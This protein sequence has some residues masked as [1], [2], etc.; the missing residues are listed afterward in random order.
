MEDTELRDVMIKGEDGEDWLE[1]GEFIRRGGEEKMREV[2][3]LEDSDRLG[4]VLGDE[5]IPDMED[6][7]EEDD[8][9]IIRDKPKLD[10]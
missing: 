2:K 10:E 3:S 6:Y 9:A 4:D 8:G 7:E 1:A 5:H